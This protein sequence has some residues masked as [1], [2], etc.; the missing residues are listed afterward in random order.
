MQPDHAMTR[1]FQFC[2]VIQL[3]SAALRLHPAAGQPSSSQTLVCSVDAQDPGSL[4]Q[5]LE[6]SRASEVVIR[7]DYSAQNSFVG[8]TTT[9]LQLTRSEQHLE[10]AL[11][12][13]A[14]EGRELGHAQDHP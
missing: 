9:P 2:V 1:S 13:A 6:D 12:E 10:Q 8:Y 14:T 11:S 5:C 4:A 3:L 7:S